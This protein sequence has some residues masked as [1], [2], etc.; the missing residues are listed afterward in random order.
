MRSHRSLILSGSIGQGHNSVAEVCATVLAEVPS[1]TEIIDC[2]EGLGGP[3]QRVGELVFRKALDRAPLYDALHFSQFR[4]GSRLA[5]TME[6]A[7][8]QRLTKALGRRSPG[9]GDLLLSVFATGAGAAGRL[10]QRDPRWRAAV[11][12]TDATAHRLW[13]H[14]GIERYFVCSMMAAATVRQYDP[15]ADV[16]ELP[17]PVRP[18]FFAAPDRTEARE[19]LDIEQGVPL[20]LLMAGGWGLGPQVEVARSLSADGYLVA[21]VAGSNPALASR[22]RHESMDTSQKGAVLPFGYTDRVPELMAAADVVIT[23]PGQTCHEARVVGRPLVVMDSVPGHGRENLLLEVTKGGA[24]ACLA[25]PDSVVAAVDAV[26][27]GQVPPADPWPIASPHEWQVQF[28]AGI[29]DLV[30]LADDTAQG[31]G[32]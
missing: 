17:P 22:L 32:T 11:F 25:Q 12:C 20:A 18:Q 10:R 14:P 3:G 16:V 8:A 31:A 19:R 23:S 28:L 24:L 29:A 4:A 9:E 21:A 1:S 30:G 5:G 27:D 7:A 26:L 15:L 6:R 13:I 2:M